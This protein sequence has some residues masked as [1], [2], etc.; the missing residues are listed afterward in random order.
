MW[1]SGPEGLHYPACCAAAPTRRRLPFPFTPHGT[2]FA[3][4]VE[5]NK[6]NHAQA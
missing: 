3:G 1:T 5:R 2:R 4:E 6:P